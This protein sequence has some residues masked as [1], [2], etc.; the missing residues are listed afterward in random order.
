MCMV[1]LSLPQVDLVRLTA[2]PLVPGMPTAPLRSQSARELRKGGGGFDAEAY[3]AAYAAAQR[4]AG[5]GGAS[6]ASS[7]T[8]GDG[9][10]DYA[11]GFGAA[12]E[13]EGFDAFRPGAAIEGGGGI[14]EELDEEDASAARFAAAEAARIAAEAAAAAEKAA[15][16]AADKENDERRRRRRQRMRK[17]VVSRI[18]W[19]LI[20]E[21]DAEKNAFREEKAMRMAFNS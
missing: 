9:F 17:P 16:E 13:G 10:D 4:E 5:A 21:L 15:K 12:G 20:D 2:Y 11:P 7:V 14:E 18:P 8:A 19:Q 6:V 3:A 1:F